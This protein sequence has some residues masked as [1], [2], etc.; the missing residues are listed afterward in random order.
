MASAVNDEELLR[1]SRHLLLPEIE[2]AG[3]ERL[4]GSGV[5]LVG[6]GGLGCPAALYLAASGVGRLILADADRVELSNLQ[7]QVLY[8]TAQLGEGKPAAAAAS[9]TALNPC[10][11]TRQLPR[12]VDAPLLQELLGEV[13][14][15]LDCSDNQST[16]YALNAA[17]FAARKPLVSAAALGW[18][19]RLAVFD[20]RRGGPC[21]R[22][23]YPDPAAPEPAACA[24]SGVAAPVVG[25]AGVLQALEALKLLS[26]AGAPLQGD[27]LVF[28][29]LLCECHRLR[30]VPRGDCPVC[31]S[32][33]DAG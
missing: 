28:D 4:R 19:A 23:L 33:E 11:T 10:V 17:C 8:R 29:G 13:D 9:I 6:L 27:V 32:R 12:R 20:P 21:Y 16:R 30:I 18:E 25:V 2:V 24:E 1:Y 14:L 26:G 7:R 22:C 5:L 31:A 15:V 3:Q